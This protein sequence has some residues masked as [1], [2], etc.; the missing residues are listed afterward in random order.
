[1]VRQFE[2]TDQNGVTRRVRLT[3]IKVNVPV[4]AAGSRFTPPKGVRVVQQ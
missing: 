2:V 1:L 3:S 4:D